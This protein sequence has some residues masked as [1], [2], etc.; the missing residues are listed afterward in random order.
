MNKQRSVQQIDHEIAKLEDQIRKLKAEKA[1]LRKANRRIGLD[2][3][4][5]E[6]LSI[7]MK[8]PGINAA[9]IHD[10]MTISKKTY[11][12]KMTGLVRRKLIV[13]EGTRAYPQ[14]YTSFGRR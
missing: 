13:N 2:D 10:Q 9:G 3:D 4:L 6:L 5:M 12:N 8:N 14:W 7:V 1:K 11:N